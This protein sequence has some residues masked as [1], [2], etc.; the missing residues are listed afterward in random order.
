MSQYLRNKEIRELNNKIREEFGIKE[1]IDKK[2]KVE[3]REDK[4]IFVNNKILFF[5]YEDK[6]VPTLN[7]ILKNNFLKKITVDMGAVKFV[8]D[9]ANIMRPG[10]T[11]V[12]DG[13]KKGELVVIIDEN[14]KK[15]LAI[16]IT[17]YSGEK[18][19]EMD[20]GNVV[21]NIHY[22]GDRIWNK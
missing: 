20:S 7:L 16:G 19:G 4:F 6:L 13:I 2:D 5:Y 21:E 15:P 9:G 18:I 10:I 14:N 11:N 17:K 3:I 8:A 1:I 12:Q 22:V